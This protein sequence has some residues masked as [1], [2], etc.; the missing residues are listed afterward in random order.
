MAELRWILLAAGLMVLFVIFLWG[1]RDK[2]LS[3]FEASQQ[4]GKFA[5]SEKADNLDEQL[6]QEIESFAISRP[7]KGQSG[8]EKS[9]PSIGNDS[10]DIEEEKVIDFG[11]PVHLHEEDLQISNIESNASS[12]GNVS[13]KGMEPKITDI[14]EAEQKH[15]QEPDDSTFQHQENQTIETSSVNSQSAEIQSDS[16]ETQAQPEEGGVIVLYVRCPAGKMV[17]GK[18]LKRAFAQQGL[19]YGDMK[20]FHRM[21]KNIKGSNSPLFGIAN[22]VEPGTFSLESM[23]EMQTPGVTVFMQLPAVVDNLTAFNDMFK[24]SLEIAESI[25]G[26]LVTQNKNPVTQ[27]WLEQMRTLLAAS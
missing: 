15:Y 20:I 14:K 13:S 16:Q 6:T 3:I 4:E 9:E 17:S 22:M 5:N 11:E 23:E 10:I 12:K 7:E 21:V 26:E 24:T 8:A 2:I 1:I 19:V 18:D 25:N 27:P